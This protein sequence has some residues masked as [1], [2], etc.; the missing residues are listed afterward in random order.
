MPFFNLVKQ[1]L[2]LS[3]EKALACPS[4]G[5]VISTQGA[6]SMWAS[7][8][9]GSTGGWLLGK[10]FGLAGLSVKTLVVS[11]SIGLV[12]FI[13]LSYFTAPIRNA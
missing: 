6:A 9:I 7:L 13:I 2:T 1:R 12:I 8:V 4:C 11:G 5:S 3:E 10:F